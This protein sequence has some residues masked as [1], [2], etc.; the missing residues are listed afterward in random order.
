MKQ[1]KKK[2][3]CPSSHHE[4]CCLTISL[5]SYSVK[6]Y[7]LMTETILNLLRM[8]DIDNHK[9]Y[10]NDTTFFKMYQKSARLREI[11][12]HSRKLVRDLRG[13]L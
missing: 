7:Y 4:N 9:Y 2:T 1:S 3:G 5:S 10:A 12:T 8:F 6:F 11:P 13:T